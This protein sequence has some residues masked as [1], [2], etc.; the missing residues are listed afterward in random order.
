MSP[1]SL[2]IK[3]RLL[4]FNTPAVMA[5]LNVT[6]DSFYAGSRATDY[7]T[8]CE[9]VRQLVDEGADFI[10]IGAYSTRP[11]CE[12]ISEAEELRR[13]EMGMKALRDVAPDIPVSV[14][15]FRSKVA[16]EAVRSLDVDIVNDISG[17]NLDDD[18]VSTVA[19]L[20]VPYVVMH[21]R[22]TPQNMG[23]FT[24]Y[25][26]FL[27][28]VLSELS[29]CIDRLHLA[30]VADIIIDPGFG[31][32][33]TLEQNYMLLKHMDLFELF[34]C[35]ILVGVSRKSMLTKLLNISAEEALEATTALNMS[36]MHR[37]A[38]I[39]RVHDVKAAKQ[40]VKIYNALQES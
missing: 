12:P 15:T 36:A 2:N 31:F 29:K 4:E 30:G 8:V 32:S 17:G 24:E 21:M 37:G 35:P 11:G 39:L 3:G 22:G 23:E 6:P 13:L 20:H 1:F 40:A 19:A 14:D 27:I 34:H 33:K 26:N 10:D 7:D 38:S 5:I 18:M 28:D 25:D 16:E 9:R